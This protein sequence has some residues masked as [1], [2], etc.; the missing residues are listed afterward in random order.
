MDK[1]VH[2][3]AY[4]ELDLALSCGYAALSLQIPSMTKPGHPI[5]E[6]VNNML[7]HE[8]NAISVPDLQSLVLVSKFAGAELAEGDNLSVCKSVL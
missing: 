8:S 6:I 2:P 5:S 3:I 1:L 4:G 7:L